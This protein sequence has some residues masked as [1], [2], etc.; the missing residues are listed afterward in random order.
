[1]LIAVHIRLAHPVGPSFPLL[2]TRYSEPFLGDGMYARKSEFRIY[3]T[4]TSTKPLRLYAYDQMWVVMALQ[5]YND[6]AGKV[7]HSSKCVRDTHSNSNCKKKGGALKEKDRLIHFENYTRHVGW[8]AKQRDAL[9][10]KALGLLSGIIHGA[11]SEIQANP[12]NAGIRTSG[13]SCFS[14]MR[15]DSMSRNL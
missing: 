14:Y 15:A 10:D 3:L 11:S 13:A 5:L 6:D 4:V 9:V 12:I 1:M 7:G 2:H 8:T